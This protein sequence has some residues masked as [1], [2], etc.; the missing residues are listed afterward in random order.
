M[1]RSLTLLEYADIFCRER[2]QLSK[3]EGREQRLVPRARAQ[4]EIFT[5]KLLLLH[6]TRVRLKVPVTAAVTFLSNQG[7]T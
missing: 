2:E 4:A 5:R 6:G 7:V 3:L 1:S